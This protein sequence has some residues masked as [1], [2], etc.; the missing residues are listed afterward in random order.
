MRYSEIAFKKLME[1]VNTKF[2]A[3]I[4]YMNTFERLSAHNMKLY[5]RKVPLYGGYDKAGRYWGY[6]KPLY[7]EYDATLKY[8]RFFR[9]GDSYRSAR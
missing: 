6:G 7:V 4:G 3:P 9:L 1:S 2:G 8:V 5:C